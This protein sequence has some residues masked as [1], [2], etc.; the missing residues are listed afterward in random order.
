MT[1]NCWTTLS[2]WISAR[3]LEVGNF[4]MKIPRR[5]EALRQKF[6]SFRAHFAQLLGRFS[7]TFERSL[8]KIAFLSLIMKHKRERSEIFKSCLNRKRKRTFN[9]DGRLIWSPWEDPSSCRTRIHAPW[10]CDSTSDTA[11]IRLGH[12]EPIV[13]DQQWAWS[14]VDW[15]RTLDLV[16]FET[17]VNCRLLSLVATEQIRKEYGGWNEYI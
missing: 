9:D 2:T 4:I 8:V 14:R 3:S 5:S 13:R 1:R 15:W 10:H 17:E 11:C 6:A 12:H 7:S 16:S